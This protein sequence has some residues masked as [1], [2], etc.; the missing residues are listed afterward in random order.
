[1]F[2]MEALLT[3]PVGLL[4]IYV[5]FFLMDYKRWHGQI[6]DENNKIYTQRK[7]D[8]LD[9]EK[10][11]YRYSGVRD[12]I[13][14]IRLTG[15]REFMNREET[16]KVIKSRE[17]ERVE[18]IRRYGNLKHI[19]EILNARSKYIKSGNVKRMYYLWKE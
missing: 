5:V 9:L 2:I 4:V 17:D 6:L 11:W 8:W 19:R 3:I 12:Y 14:Y 16:A 1:M 13:Y 15:Y 18:R 10:G 7:A